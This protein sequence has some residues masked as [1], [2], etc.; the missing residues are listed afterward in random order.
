MT[1]AIPVV[2]VFGILA[3]VFRPRKSPTTARVSAIM[4]TAI[5]PFVVAVAAIVFQLLYNA[6]AKAWV[7]DIPNTCYI[8]GLCLIG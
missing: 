2:I 1:V 7:L 8:I 6:T 4:A 5:P 3:W